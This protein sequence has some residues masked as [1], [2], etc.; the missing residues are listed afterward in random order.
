ME[1]LL[2]IVMAMELE[3]S[4]WIASPVSELNRV[5]TCVHETPGVLI[6]VRTT[7][8]CHLDVVSLDEIV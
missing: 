8:M 1:Q 5:S 3:K 4:G 2:V 7:K 6:V